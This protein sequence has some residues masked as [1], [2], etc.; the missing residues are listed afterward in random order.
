MP[1]LRPESVRIAK[2]MLSGSIKL[3]DGCKELARIGSW[4]TAH[5]EEEDWSGTRDSDFDVFKQIDS[6]TMDYPF[7]D[8]RRHWSNDALLRKDAQLAQFESKQREE[9][10]AAC[11]RL[12]EKFSD[13]L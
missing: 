13:T 3:V 12:L 6:E 1:E 4:W 2:A 9:I 8:V 10:L 11:R 7:G 5:E